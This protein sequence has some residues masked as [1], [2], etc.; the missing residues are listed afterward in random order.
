[1]DY[2]GGKKTTGWGEKQVVPVVLRV[3]WTKAR[4]KES[5]VKRPPKLPR[6]NR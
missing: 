6:R 2:R 1:L 3:G 4:K 5:K